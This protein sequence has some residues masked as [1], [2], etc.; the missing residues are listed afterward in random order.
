MKAKPVDWPAI[1]REYMTTEV[2]DAALAARWGFKSPTTITRKRVQE[3][4]RRDVKQVA[5]G[6]VA[7]AVAGTARDR[8]T[9]RGHTSHT[10]AGPSENNDLE[11]Q[12]GSDVCVEPENGAT[13][14]AQPEQPLT[15]KEVQL[16]ARDEAE[17]ESLATATDLAQVQADAIRQQLHLGDRLASVGSAFLELLETVA[18]AEPHSQEY[19]E[20]VARLDALKTGKDTLNTLMKSTAG[21][22]E[23]GVKMQRKALRM[24]GTGPGGDD[25]GKS[26]PSQQRR[27]EDVLPLLPLAVLEAVAQAANQ[28]KVIRADTAPRQI[29]GR[30]EKVG[31]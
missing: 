14:A 24:D 16:Q 25:A 5:A 11:P 1:K 30:A 22:V 23:S 21:L 7:K 27:M 17:A 4:W 3:G 15:R 13:R 31:S 9:H 6:L 18:K 20:A 19:H 29:E 28:A 26:Q 12:R 2:S 10:H 8:A